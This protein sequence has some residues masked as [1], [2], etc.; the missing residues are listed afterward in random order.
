MFLLIAFLIMASCQKETEQE[1]LEEVPVIVNEWAVKDFIDPG[2]TVSV[3]LIRT[4][5]EVDGFV[6]HYA[7]TIF[8]NSKTGEYKLVAPWQEDIRFK[9]SL[10]SDQ[11]ITRIPIDNIP[12]T[13]KNIWTII[14]QIREN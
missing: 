5:E 3:L 14:N 11:G 6:K 9:W 8:S 2:D 4:N 13:R 1:P 7:R 10:L 12:L